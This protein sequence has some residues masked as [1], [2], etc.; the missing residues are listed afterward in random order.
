MTQERERLL[1]VLAW[2]TVT[3]GHGGIPNEHPVQVADRDF[4]LLPQPWGVLIEQLSEP[5]RLSRVLAEDRQLVRRREL[6][7]LLDGLLRFRLEALKRRD[8][9]PDLRNF[10]PAHEA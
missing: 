9:Q 4:D 6:F 8:G 7:Q 3:G 2:R 1:V 5:L 10:L